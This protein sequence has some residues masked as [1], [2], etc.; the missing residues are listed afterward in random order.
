LL[1][2][3]LGELGYQSMCSSILGYGVEATQTA[4]VPN[5]ET[6]ATT[7]IDEVEVTAT[8]NT[9]EPETS[10]IETAARE[11]TGDAGAEDTALEA[12]YR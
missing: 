9:D 3:I 11:V 1:A 7:I 6:V 10:A 12:R 4:L 8:A 2:G 5:I